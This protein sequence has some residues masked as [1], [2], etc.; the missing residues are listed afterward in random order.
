MKRFKNRLT[1]LMPLVCLLAV[2]FLLRSTTHAAESE[3]TFDVLQTRTGTYTNVTV[4]AKNKDWIFILHSAG[5]VNIRIAD[6]SAE[7]QEALGYAEPKKTESQ[8][9]TAMID[10]LSNMEMPPMAELEKS[11]RADGPGP[12]LAAAMKA[13]I[14]WI[15]LGIFAAG[16][17]FFCFCSM[18]ICQKAGTS[19]G[20]LVWIP[21]FQMIP[22]LRAARMPLLWFLAYLI[23]VVNIIAQIVWYVKIVDARGKPAIVIFFLLLPITFPLAYMY[24]AFS[25][26]A[27]AVEKEKIMPLVLETA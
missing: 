1:G 17:L 20:L 13:K 9:M 23:P 21:V 14:V 4:T 10:S 6:L 8:E 19:P 15:I 5:M 26:G 27:P 7:A 11:W 16:Y 25:D 18:K 3:E 2:L 12:L 22:L 24:L